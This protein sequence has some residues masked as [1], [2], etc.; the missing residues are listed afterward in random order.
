M[1]NFDDGVQPLE[2]KDG[3]YTMAEVLA[4]AVKKML[5]LKG[6]I[7]LSREPFIRERPVV[8]FHQRMRVDGLEKFSARTVF[9]SI[10]FF[11][12]KHQMD[13]EHAVGAMVVY[14][15]VDYIAKLMWLMEYGRIDEDEDDVVLD[16]CGTITNLIGGY[17]V[18][19]LSGQGFIF[20]E[21]SHFESFINTAVNGINFSPD[22]ESKF[23]IEFFIR[24]EKKI[25]AELTM[26]KLPRY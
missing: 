7:H 6:D 24:N 9:S 8:Q 18:K 10:V 13:V 4:W 17:F 3:L 5:L 1:S 26:G 14:I 21:M 19:E 20:L 16:A 25:V 15:P 12:D 23:E 11:K 2:H 22:Q